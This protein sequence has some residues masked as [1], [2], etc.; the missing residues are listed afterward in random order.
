MHAPYLLIYK[1]KILLNL[2]DIV[3]LA[4]IF[5]GINPK[6]VILEL[7]TIKKNEIKTGRLQVGTHLEL[8][9]QTLTQGFTSPRV[10]GKAQVAAN[11]VLEQSL[12]GLLGQLQHHLAENH[13]NVGKPGKREST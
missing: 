5:E 9:W 11:H 2:W 3:I 12:T 1:S 7:I 8:V 10:V 4:L 13:G 6:H